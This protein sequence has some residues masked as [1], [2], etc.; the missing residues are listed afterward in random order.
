MPPVIHS[1]F[2]GILNMGWTVLQAYSSDRLTRIVKNCIYCMFI[3]RAE[4]RTI[5]K[6]CILR[7]KNYREE[8]PESIFHPI[9]SS[10]LRHRPTKVNMSL[11]N[12]E[13][14]FGFLLHEQAHQKRQNLR[15]RMALLCVCFM[16]VYEKWLNPLSTPK[17]I[18]G[19]S[20]WLNYQLRSSQS[21]SKK[22]S[23]YGKFLCHS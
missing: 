4:E 10:I 23:H 20:K 6:V 21:D 16:H 19:L 18:Y 11:D 22:I 5:T 17:F 2:R 1:N 13:T 14:C 12:F 9:P 15:N 8:E 3:R 7:S